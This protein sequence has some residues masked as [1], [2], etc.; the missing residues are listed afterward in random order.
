MSDIV[1]E[2]AP[3][4]ED[5]LEIEVLNSFEDESGWYFMISAN[6]EIRGELVFARRGKDEKIALVEVDDLSLGASMEFDL[7]E[8][9]YRYAD[10]YAAQH[11]DQ[12]DLEQGF[13]SQN[14]LDRTM[15]IKAQWGVGAD[16]MDSSSAKGTEGGRLACAWAVNRMA[17]L[18]LGRAIG[19]GL[20]TAEMVKVLRAGHIPRNTPDAGSVIISPSVYLDSGKKITGHVGILGDDNLIY[21]NSSSRAQWEQN[22]TTSSWN[23]YYRDDKGLSVEIYGLNPSKFPL[24][25]YFGW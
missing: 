18:A 2:I 17:Q 11:L 13:L 23:A 7:L 6:D 20:A 3:L 5:E 25:K 14:E 22:Y 9:P 19:G 12:K 16:E 8:F 21:S 1:S 10:E 24:E 4:L 15:Y